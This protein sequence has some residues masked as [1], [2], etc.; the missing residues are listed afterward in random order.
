MNKVLLVDDEPWVLEGLK[1]MINWE[2]HGFQICGEAC[3]GHEAWGMIE[4]LKPEL[5]VT[6]IQMPVLNGLELIKRSN[7]QL[8]VPPKF[9]ILS[10]FNDFAYAR[11][12]LRYKVTEYLLKPIDDEEVN[13]LLIK[14]RKKIDEEIEQEELQVRKQIYAVNNVMNRL[15]QG[16]YS[17][18]LSLQASVSLHLNLEAELQCLLIESS[19]RAAELNKWAGS[20]FPHKVKHIFQDS[21]GRT[22]VLVQL[23]Q[24]MD[25]Q[26]K[27]AAVEIYKKLVEVSEQPIRIAVSDITSG[28]RSIRSLYLQTMEVIG[29]KRSQGKSGVCSY[30]DIKAI[31]SRSKAYQVNLRPLLDTVKS[32]HIDKIP[33]TIKEIFS[34]LIDHSSNIETF[35]AEVAS[36]E[37]MICRLIAEMKGDPN[38]LMRNLHTQYGTLESVGNYPDLEVYV[39]QLCILAAARLQELQK[40][41]ECNTIFHVIQYIDREYRGKIQLQELAR[42][43]HMNA[44]YLGQLFKK[45]TGK[46]FNDYL[47]EKRIEEAKQLLKRTNMK[48]SDVAVQVGYPNK[49]Y[50][51]NKF[52]MITGVLPSEFKHDVRKKD[53][54]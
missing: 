16:E 51:I 10:G 45:N 8:T 20:Y 2:D 30:E 39:E 26:L 49:D 42:Q 15:I 38:D 25:Y 4:D 22:G 31:Q 46:S 40:E 32:E 14:L 1:T 52:K 23:E 11:A 29:V 41:N 3:N 44:A 33:G 36:L 35:K 47:N 18:S 28:I 27:D 17:D 6:D 13:M 53:L 34:S 12:A 19:F 21:A 9:V 7:Q 24:H 50:F 37:L 48:I 5:V 43:F 54:L